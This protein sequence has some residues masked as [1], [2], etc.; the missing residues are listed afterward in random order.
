MLAYF[1]TFAQY[2]IVCEEDKVLE[3]HQEGTLA[4]IVFY[5]TTKSINSTGFC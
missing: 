5:A 4:L 3:E 2:L 1:A